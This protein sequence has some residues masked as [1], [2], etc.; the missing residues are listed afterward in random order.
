MQSPHPVS[1]RFIS[2]PFRA[3]NLRRLA[4]RILL[5]LLLSVGVAQTSGYP[6][7]D[8]VDVYFVIN[9]GD[10]ANAKGDFTLA[11]IKYVKAYQML[12][13]FQQAY[14]TWNKEIVTFRLNYLID[15]IKATAAQAASTGDNNTT[16]GSG[17]TAAATKSPVKLLDAGS[18]PRVALRLHPGIG[19]QQ[20]LN[21]TVKI[22]IEMAAG[23]NS[24]PAMNLPAFGIAMNAQVLEIAPNG[25]IT[26]GFTYDAINVSTDDK[27]SPQIAAA[28]NATLGHLRG[29][30]GT[31][32]MSDHG[33]ILG[34]HVKLP[35]AAD[36]QLSQIMDQVKDSFSSS[37][38][39]FP[40]EPVGPGAKWEC[41]TKI[42]SQGLVIN[43]TIT[44][45]LL[46]VEGEQVNLQTTITQSA[47]NQKV[48]N[49]TV[50][51]LKMDLTKM[52]GNGSGTTTFNL[53]RP[54]PQSA[55]LNSSME[56]VMAFDIGQQ[57]Q[58]M[59]M[60]VQNDVSVTSK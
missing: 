6:D 10:E 27:S 2:T 24:M 52:S 11:Q 34:S 21:L 8:Y 42:K 51:G 19:E 36:P 32:K 49:P 37:A 13:A 31:N 26:Y 20:S 25:D 41:K 58:A 48:Q 3:T 35:A 16:A 28:L 14:P 46:S 59:S 18:E 57:K 29:L 33:V 56:M 43:Q 45:E 22:G 53:T 7:D 1:F 9:S 39:P 44:S 5:I 54:L 15:Q 50:P 17:K 12:A 55:K 4:A 23:E 38:S 40:N 47:A 60:K 30:S